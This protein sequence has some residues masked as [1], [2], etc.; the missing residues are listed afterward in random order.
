MV[1][2]GI[3][4]GCAALATMIYRH[5]FAGEPI[6]FEDLRKLIILIPLGALMLWFRTDWLRQMRQARR[7]A[8]QRDPERP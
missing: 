5:L 2:Y 1:L 4:V 7:N 3:L 8:K 6:W